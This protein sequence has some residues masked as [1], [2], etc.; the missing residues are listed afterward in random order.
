MIRSRFSLLG[1][2][3]AVGLMAFAA[4]SAQAETGAKWLILE[5]VGGNLVPQTEMALGAERLEGSLE[6]STA[7]LLSEIGGTKISIKCT[8]V[9]L[10][11]AIP[12]VNGGVREGARIQFTGCT[13]LGGGANGLETEFT[14]C[15]VKTEGGPTGFFKTTLSHALLKLNGNDDILLFLPDNAEGLLFKLEMGTTCAFGNEVKIFGKFA[16]QDC[17]GNTKSLEHLATHL[18]SEYT[19]ATKIKLFKPEP[20]G[21]TARIDGSINASLASGRQFSGDPA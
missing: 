16:V 1:V 6:N 18:V 17:G 8:A 15:E 14:K 21:T 4:S 5:T 3:L 13:V 10:V 20:N 12:A 9:S 11:N 19:A 7:S 2:L